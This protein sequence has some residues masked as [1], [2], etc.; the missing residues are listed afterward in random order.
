MAIPDPEPSI[1][2]A[3]SRSSAWEAP[4][5][6]LGFVLAVAGATWWLYRSPDPVSESGRSKFEKAE[7]DPNYT[8]YVGDR[9]CRECHPGESAAHSRSGHSRTLRAANQ[10]ASARNLDGREVADPERAGVSWRFNFGEGRLSTERLEAGQS[11]RFSIEYA[12]G[13]GRHAL[14][15]VSLLDRDP[16]NPSLIEHRLT[17]FAHAGDLGLTPGQKEETHN[18]GNT[19]HG[20]VHDAWN[21]LKCFSCHVTTTSS[22][23]PSFLDE[24]TMIPNVSCERCHGPAK[25]HVEAARRGAAGDELAM[26][27]RLEEASA[28]DQIRRCGE[29][30]R[31]PEMITAGQIRVDNTALVRHQPVGLMQSA[32]FLKSEGKLNCSTCHDPHARASTDRV[33]YQGRCLT[34]HGMPDQ[35]NCPVSPRDGCIDCHMP[36]RDVG[37]GMMMSDHWIRVVPE[38]RR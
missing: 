14:T 23:G 19:P 3:P 21:T 2:P 11:E 9:S 12:F 5:I 37:R 31:T 24:P 10:V 28:L 17:E 35:T 36:R 16:A 13:S 38:A 30:H 25:G 4:A 27:F 33:S 15:F 7:V 8:R 22:R 32:C 6:G 18:S 34:C 20:R 29:C 1:D 26:P